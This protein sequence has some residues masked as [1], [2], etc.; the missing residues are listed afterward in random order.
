MAT[1]CFT[2]TKGTKEVGICVEN[3]SDVD[4]YL[5]TF[6]ESE[7][8]A[9]KTVSLMNGDGE[10]IECTGKEKINNDYDYIYTFE[11][12]GAKISVFIGWKYSIQIEN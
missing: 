12:K 7:L 9:Y 3:G 11:V 4:A 6:N 1:I 5:V 2:V 8:M 10:F